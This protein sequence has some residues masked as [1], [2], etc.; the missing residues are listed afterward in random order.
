[1]LPQGTFADT[2]DHGLG[3]YANFDYNFNKFLA[4]R[5]DLGW[6]DISGP[7]T[8]YLDTLGFFHTNHPNMSVCEF[9]A[10][11]RG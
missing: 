2:Y 1:M 11:L 6:N 8:Q 10:G 5:F 4:A 3:I 7:E 9:T